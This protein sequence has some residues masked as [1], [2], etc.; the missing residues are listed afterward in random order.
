MSV[1]RLS[2]HFLCSGRFKLSF[3]SS[4]LPAVILCC[5]SGR[6]TELL[7][8]IVQLIV[9]LVITTICQSVQVSPLHFVTLRE[10]WLLF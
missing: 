6:D 10:I 7:L 9:L 1:C 8:R 5:V 3:P 2:V 4:V